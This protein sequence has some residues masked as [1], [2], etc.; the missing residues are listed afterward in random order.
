M[1]MWRAE[2]AETFFARAVKLDPD[3]AWARQRLLLIRTSLG[4]CEEPLAAAAARPLEPADFEERVSLAGVMLAADCGP[5]APA[6][7]FFEGLGS[8]AEETLEKVD[9]SN[10]TGAQRFAVTALATAW[11]AAGRIA[12]EN[13][14]IPRA[15]T[16]LSAAFALLPSATTSARRADALRAQG[17]TD[18]ADYHLALAAALPSLQKPEHQKRLEQAIPSVGRRSAYASRAQEGTWKSWSQSVQA[19]AAAGVEGKLWLVYAPDGRL[20]DARPAG[21]DSVA[22]LVAALKANGSSLQ[23]PPGNRAH[24]PRRAT[25]HC[26]SDGSCTLLFDWVQG[27]YGAT[28]AP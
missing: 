15:A 25:A 28:T 22:P 8:Q 16:Y 9:V 1:E 23:L 7:A 14:D 10:P 21:A 24:I 26:N 17:D 12:L 11:D 5:L 19:P 2:E 18:G 20:L 3:D 27:E 13:G 4:R 6:A